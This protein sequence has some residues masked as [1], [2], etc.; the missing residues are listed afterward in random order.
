[1]QKWIKH[2][3]PKPRE[4]VNLARKFVIPA[5]SVIPAPCPSEALC[6]G[7]KAGIQINSFG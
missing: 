1:M 3:T 7:G 4:R 2:L 6:E 5:S